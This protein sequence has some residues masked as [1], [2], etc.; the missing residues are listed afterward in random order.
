MARFYNRL[1]QGSFTVTVEIDPPKSADVQKTL[2]KVRR[3]WD[4]VDAVNVADCPMANVRMSPITLAHLIQRDAGVEAIFH[5]TCRDRNV[6][7]LQAELLGA[8]G[9]GVRN[10]LALHGD[11]PARGDHPSAKGVFEVDSAGLIQVA[12]TLNSGKTVSGKDLDQGTD[13]AIGCVTN[14]TASDLGAEVARLEEKVAAGAHFVQTQPVYDPRSLERW[15]A[16]ID[17]RVDVPI[18]YGILPLKSYEFASHLSESVP[19]IEVPEWALER[20]KRGDKDEGLQL[21]R[22]L[23]SEIHTMVHGVHIFPMN[24]AGRVLSVV[25]IL[26]D[27]GALGRRSSAIGYSGHR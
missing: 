18:L 9:L 14:P 15:L 11:D 21:V 7:G 26:D 1:I 3:F 2:E 22:E 16:R 24:N 19:G 12:S 4:R 27:V 8:A 17:G 20:M 5:L 23:I 6:I 25:D 13:F 10:I